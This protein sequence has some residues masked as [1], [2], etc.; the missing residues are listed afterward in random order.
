[1]LACGEGLDAQ[2]PAHSSSPASGTGDP[3]EL[4]QDTLMARGFK[5]SHAGDP[6]ERCAMSS[7]GQTP[8][9]KIVEVADRS[10]FCANGNRSFA[11]G[12]LFAAD[13]SAKSF[14]S[15]KRGQFNLKFDTSKEHAQGCSLWRPD[16]NGQQP[17]HRGSRNWDWSHYLLNQYLVEDIAGITDAE[18]SELDLENRDFTFS[19]DVSLNR[20]RR[21]GPECGNFTQGAGP[22]IKNH[23]I[24]YM[25]FVLARKDTQ[26]TEARAD[27]IYLVAPLNFFEGEHPTGPWLGGDA[28]STLVYIHDRDAYKVPVG[29]GPRHV[30]IQVNQ[31]A[32]SAF[33]KIKRDKGLSY[34]LDDYIVA[35]VLFG[36]ELWGGYETD[37]TFDNISLKKS[38]AYVGVH[39]YFSRPL[40]DHYLTTTYAGESFDPNVQYNYEG[41]LG[42]LLKRPRAGTVALNQY[43]SR[44]N[45]DHAYATGRVAP[46]P[47]AYEF[48]KILGYVYTEPTQAPGL[49]PIHEYYHP[50]GKDHYYTPT[51]FSGYGFTYLGSEWLMKR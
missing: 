20:L 36:W 31:L 14:T 18:R 40:I 12:E 42:K 1:M 29:V 33:A 50:Y 4:L 28:N 21:S 47:S 43:L 44:N 2:D 45:S 41:I 5:P 11:S 34:Q 10:Y 9:W 51:P 37:V 23:A 16:A 39:K 8:A 48:E 3:D 6:G 24:L 22:L 46:E 27:G 49:M 25:G 26:Q 35:E 30:E 38:E 17:L 19:V 13:A 32:E 7:P 15:N